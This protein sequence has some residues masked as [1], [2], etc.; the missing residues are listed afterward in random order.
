MHS[1]PVSAHAALAV[2]LL[3]HA[4]SSNSPLAAYIRSLARPIDF[5]HLPLG[6]PTELDPLLPP[7]TLAYLTKQRAQFDLHLNEAR[8]LVDLYPALYGSIPLPAA[9]DRT[10]TAP[11]A[12]VAGSGGGDV[13]GEDGFGFA[14]AWHCVNSRTIYQALSQTSSARDNYSMAP[15]VDMLNHAPSRAKHCI[16]RHTLSS[17][18]V[19]F[20]PTPAHAQGSASLDGAWAADA[21]HDAQDGARRRY[22]AG[23]EV[24]ICYGAHA[25]DV[26]L[27]DYGFVPASNP[28]DCLQ[29]DASLRRVAMLSSAHIGRLRSWGYLDDYTVDRAG[30]PSFRVL[31]ALQLSLVD[32]PIDPESGGDEELGAATRDALRRVVHFRDGRNSHPEASNRVD[33]LLEQVLDLEQ[34]AAEEAVR[35]APR[36]APK[37]I[38]DLIVALWQGRLSIIRAARARLTAQ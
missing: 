31:V 20:E 2:H 29:I 3:H 10:P 15:F 7:S 21:E 33:A 23:E 36:Q 38:A 27:C 34:Q 28:D 25:N 37:Q 8:K 13:E 16:L 14:W 26:L 30:E 6:W 11:S 24:C 19:V 1:S 22:D 18:Q 32:L 12:T 9:T 17:L 35:K 5:A 4:L